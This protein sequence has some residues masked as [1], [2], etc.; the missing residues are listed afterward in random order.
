MQIAFLL[1]DDVNAL[2]A[3]GAYEVLSNLPRAEVVWVAAERGPK[4]A[5]RGL[6]LIATHVLGEVPRP[7]VVVVPGGFGER[8]AGQ[9]PA[10]LSWLRQV[11]ETASWTVSVCTGA[12]LLGRAGLLQGKRATT[13]WLALP[14]LASYGAEAVSERWVVDGRI[15]TSAGVS[16]G[17]DM[18]LALAARIAG[19]TVAQAVQLGIE[20]DPRP[21]FSAGSPAGAGPEIVSL[22]R[23]RYAARRAGL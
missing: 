22:V 2:D 19:E 13:Y 21:P 11:H 5:V 9:D 15:C 18:S 7:D 16:A 12:L 10:V 20:Y 8:T 4:R 3:V 23:A 6:N 1:F 17:I 14:E